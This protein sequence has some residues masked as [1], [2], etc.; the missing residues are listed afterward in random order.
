MLFALFAIQ[1]YSADFNS[2]DQ[3]GFTNVAQHFSLVCCLLFGVGTRKTDL[4]DSKI[5]KRR[6]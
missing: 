6:I 1:L 5:L 2:V 3:A 4:Y